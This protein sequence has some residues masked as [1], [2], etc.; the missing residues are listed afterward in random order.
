M[1]SRDLLETQFLLSYLLDEPGRPEAWLSSDPKSSPEEYKPVVIR[2]YLDKRD[3]F[4]KRKREQSY[5]A[6]STLGAHPSPGGL[7]LKRDGGRA[8]HGGP[9]KQRDTLEQCI[10]E[11]ARVILPLCGILHKYCVSE[12][13]S[14]RSMASRLSLILQRTQLKYFN[15]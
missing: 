7:E 9:F 2:K 1:Y 10:Q 4:V 14:G 11:A 8:I 5:K 13:E 12:I 6:L 3:G 15:S